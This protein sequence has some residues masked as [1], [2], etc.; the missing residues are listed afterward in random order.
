MNEIEVMVNVIIDYIG[1]NNRRKALYIRN[2]LYK[3]I[4]S[5]YFDVKFILLRLA[6]LEIQ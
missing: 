1:K 6:V 3:T 4:H 2:N 5:E